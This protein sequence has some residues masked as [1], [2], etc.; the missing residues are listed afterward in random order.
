MV[1]V[2]DKYRQEDKPRPTEKEKGSLEGLPEEKVGR[3]T[4]DDYKI[5]WGPHD[6]GA[7]KPSFCYSKRNEDLAEEITK[8]ERTLA[9]GYVSPER[10]MVFES[11]LKA[12]KDRLEG[13]N[14]N[15]ERVRGIVNKNRE[16][17]Q[18]RRE[19]L[20]K[21]I[22]ENEPTRKDV[23]KKRVNPYRVA[24][25][26]QGELGRA[27]KEYIVISRALG[28]ESNVSFLQRD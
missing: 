25:M 4:R 8:M 24:K 1:K 13:L 19:E 17:W 21:Y 12:K 14:A 7:A 2:A 26:E 10:K 28:E 6:K 3:V 27:K 5:F 16:G 15:T 20:G 23:E 11:K 9:M 22:A 18:R